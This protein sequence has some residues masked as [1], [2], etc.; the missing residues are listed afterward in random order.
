VLYLFN[1]GFR[2]L[3]V[4][5]VL[6]TLF[7]PE[8]C[9]NEYRY[10]YVGEPRHVPPAVYS[11]LPELRSGMECVLCFIDRFGAT[12]YNYH[13]L[14]LGAYLSNREANGYLYFRIQLGTLLYPRDL[15]AFKHHLL[16]VLDPLGLP[17][18]TANDPE[19]ASDGSYAIL[20]ESIFRQADE[21]LKD[22]AAWTAAVEDLSKTRALSTNSEQS[23]IFIRIDVHQPSTD[24]KRIAP[25]LRDGAS[26]YQLEKDKSHE[27]SLTYRFPRQRTDQGARARVEIKLGDNLRGQTSF[28]IDSH[29]NSVLAPFSSKRYMEDSSGSITLSPVDE[30]GQPSLLISDS[31]L[32]Y[33]IRESTAFWLQMAGALLM[34]SLA[35]AF[36]GVDFSKLCPFSV[37]AFFSAAWPKLIAGLIQTAA[38]FWVFRLIGKKVV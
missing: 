25:V 23:P 14:R 24:S 32:R 35:G 19:N 8:G 29:A 10:R 17:K 28:S 9:T 11:K 38:L 6:N 5:N 34:F 2:P 1:S 26:I 21:Y 27:L 33:E 3:Y 4:R 7:L 36:I 12:G 30:S 22:D 20:A 18:L 13:P 37:Q 16:E 31:S 15:A